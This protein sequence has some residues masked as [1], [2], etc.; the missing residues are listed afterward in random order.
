M[1]SQSDEFNLRIVLKIDIRF[2][3]LTLL[4]KKV[5]GTFMPIYYIFYIFPFSGQPKVCDVIFDQKMSQTFTKISS[6]DEVKQCR[7]ASLT[8]ILLRRY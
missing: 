2:K 6:S 7:F 8:V 3:L 5:V 4:N 1:N